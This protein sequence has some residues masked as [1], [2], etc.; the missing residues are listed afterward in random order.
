MGAGPEAKLIRQAH[1]KRIKKAADY[2][3][4]FL[5]RKL[6]KIIRLQ[7]LQQEQL[8]QLEQQLLRPQLQQQRQP[9]LLHLLQL[10]W[11]ERDAPEP[12]CLADPWSGCCVL[13]AWQ[14]QPDRG[15][16]E[17]D[18]LAV[19]PVQSNAG[20]GQRRAIRV[21]RLLQALGSMHQRFG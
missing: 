20:C 8:L 15:S 17:R 6:R 16:E 18:R 14:Y 5:N 19:R 1:V 9:W 3:A 12:S 7:L 2:S 11:R 10:A 13:H 21:Q 4:A